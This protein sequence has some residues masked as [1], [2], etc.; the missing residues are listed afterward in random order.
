MA[1]TVHKLLF[2]RGTIDVS[3]PDSAQAHVTQKP[4]FP[5][6]AAASEVF[7]AAMANP[8]DSRTLDVLCERCRNACILICDI[9][10]PVPN[11]EF[12]RPMIETMISAGIAKPSFNTYKLLNALGSE[13][14][15]AD[16]PVLASKRE[17]GMIAAL[18]WNL[19]E[20]TQPSG[21]PGLSHS[22]SLRGEAKTL[23]VDIAG[24]R[25]GQSVSV[26]YVDQERGSP[27]PAWREMGSPQ[28]PSRQQIDTLRQRA[29][30]APAQK[31]RLDRQGRLTLSLPPEGVALLELQG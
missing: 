8:V 15:E 27:M 21:I 13:R 18:V 24:A 10:R 3:L 9:T 6:A 31:M 30:I 7:A 4:D 1:N 19:A 11:H 14:L 22:R 23:L 17:D 26:R 16:G 28:Y 29:D 2:G 5:P 25:P 12:L 20:V